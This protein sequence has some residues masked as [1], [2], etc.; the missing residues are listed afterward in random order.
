MLSSVENTRSAPSAAL[1]EAAGLIEAVRPVSA[2]PEYSGSERD[3]TAVKLV[4][5]V[6]PSEGFVL[7]VSFPDA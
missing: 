4:N 2:I 3:S 5:P 6:N 1:T 7:S